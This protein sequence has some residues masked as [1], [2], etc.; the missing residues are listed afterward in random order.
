M[1]SPFAA[2]I[3]AGFA[4]GIISLGLPT[5]ASAQ[6]ISPN[7][8]IT[9]LIGTSTAVPGGT[10]NFAV[11]NPD[12]GHPPSPCISGGNLVFWGASSTGQGI[13]VA[14]PPG[15]PSKVSDTTTAIP[16][17]IG[18]F[19]GHPPSPCISGNNVVFQGIGQGGQQGIYVA[20]PPGPPT[21]PGGA[22][23]IPPGP[24]NKIA[25][26]NTA[27]PGG[28]G[29]FTSFGLDLA[30]PPSPC[31][32]G[33][34]VAFMASGLGGQQGIYVAFPPGPPSRI[35]D[36]NT[37]I[38]GGEGNFTSFT[39]DLTH[40][41]SP[42]ISGSN[43]VFIGTGSSGQQGIYVAIPPGPPQRIADTS[44]V[45][46]GLLQ[47]FAGFSAVA[48]SGN[49]VAFVGGPL[50][51]TD[52][53]VIGVAAISPGVYVT[54]A[55]G[56]PNKIA[57]LNTAVPGGTG[58]FLGFG[59]VAIDAGNVVF[60]GFGRNSVGAFEQGLFT[61]LGGT[62][63]KIVATT[64]IIN[65]Q[66][67]AVINFR[68]GGFSGNQ[69]TF[70]A[71]FADGSQSIAMASVGG[72]ECP[73][74]PGYWEEHVSNWPVTSLSL[75]SQNYNQSQLLALLDNSADGDASL[76]LAR[77]LIA[78][79]LNLANNSNPA[80]VGGAISDSDALLAVFTGALPYQVN[81]ESAAGKAMLNA[82]TVLHNYNNGDFASSCKQKEKE[83]ERETEHN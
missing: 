70:E 13:Y 11:F 62:L 45:V 4:I 2:S 67:L 6:T 64:D 19:L 1:K 34:N 9:T 29:N 12:S 68:A 54:T 73:R 25:D 40:P 83:N 59:A 58:N 44:T 65:G 23:N 56:P 21:I 72:N 43:V 10:G 22:V 15:P 55:P 47:N 26:L 57:D 8:S 31:I 30:H 52:I 51:Q 63:T 27:I 82:A 77:Q 60:E 66:T 78:A 5:A 76:I 81:A 41:P 49:N 46:P 36:L 53:T 3:L 79:K 38:P 80:P 61:N 42:C 28:A 20:L 75:G 50:A 69:V 32:S 35:A 18:N 74:S 14:L 7:V 33:N 39:P 71:E 16:G 37:A 48:I 17:G 24:P